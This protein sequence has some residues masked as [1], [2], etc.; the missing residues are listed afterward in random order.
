MGESLRGSDIFALY[1]ENWLAE[2]D[3]VAMSSWPVTKPSRAGG[4]S[5]AWQRIE[6]YREHKWL[7]EQLDDY[8]RA[9][10][11]LEVDD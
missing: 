9:D 7:R 11:A 3:D 5:T 6:R 4:R 10:F 2:D 8:G 1:D